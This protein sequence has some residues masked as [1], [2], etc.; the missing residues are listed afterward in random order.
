M[1]DDRHDEI[2]RPEAAV[3]WRILHTTERLVTDDQAG[4][5]WRRGA[6]LS[7]NE[8]AIGSAHAEQ[9]RANQDGAVLGT[10]DLELLELE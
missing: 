1:T 4:V 6:V 5:S 3:G 7:G 10:V 9:Q 8:L 2:A